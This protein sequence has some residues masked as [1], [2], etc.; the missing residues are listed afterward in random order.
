VTLSG[1]IVGELKRLRSRTGPEQATFHVPPTRAG[2]FAA[3]L[4]ATG[5]GADH[6][7]IVIANVVFEPRHLNAAVG[8]NDLEAWLADETVIDAGA[9]E[10]Q[11]LLTAGLSDW[12]DFWFAPSPGG[13]LLFADHDE[14]STVFAHKKGVVSR[15]SEAL[16]AAGFREVVGFER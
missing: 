1:P 10:A 5:A 6:A 8:R 13:F 11:A 2:D 3:T 12:V 15:A 4:L 16:R 14:W 7:R 9:G